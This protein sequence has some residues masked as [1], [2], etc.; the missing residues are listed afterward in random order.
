MED[1]AYLERR[2]ERETALAETAA[3]A[4]V[5]AVHRQFAEAYRGR[6][7]SMAAE[8]FVLKPFG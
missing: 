4:G 7:D 6:L 1:R 5:R 2:L 3:D 8:R